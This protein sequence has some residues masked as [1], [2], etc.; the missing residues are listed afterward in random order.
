M[1][2]KNLSWE[3]AV[4]WLRR[5]PNQQDLVRA[6]FYDDPLIE[7]AHR[8]Y[9]STEW[10]AVQHLLREMPVGTVLDV[11]AGRGISSYSFARDGWKVTALEPDPSDVVG[12]GAISE[13]VH[14]GLNIDIEQAHGEEL[15][16][17]D[18]SFNLVYGRAVL[19]H[20]ADLHRFCGEL[21]R[22]L[23]PGGRFLFTREH[24][25][26]NQSDLKTFQENHPLHFLYGGEFAYTVDEY[27]EAL[28]SR[29][30]V[31]LSVIKTYS[32]DINLYPSSYSELSRNIKMKKSLPVPHWFI[33][34]YIIPKL[35]RRNQAAGR[36]YSFWG[37]KAEG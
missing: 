29:S 32:S 27:M 30:R 12:T 37:Q 23:Q 20:A 9:N 26:S 34:S 14:D 33:K 11:G 35:N 3:E 15:P 17:K 31:R 5:Q 6:C 24:V 16:F 13:L 8:Y 7:S 1:T 28:E 25:I 4:E 21:L 36:L 18:N 19:H 10:K 22:V 2:V